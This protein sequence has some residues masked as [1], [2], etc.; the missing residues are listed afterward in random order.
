M[1][2]V[3]FSFLLSIIL[4]FA[5]GLAG[6]SPVDRSESLKLVS[7]DFELADGPSWSGWALTV[8]DPKSQI[9]K[10]FI[11]KQKKWHVVAKE[12]RFSASFFNHGKTYFAS[13]RQPCP[14]QTGY[15]QH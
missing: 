3:Q 14:C 9:A 8:P 15:R 11:L 2:P 1:K 12:K 7:D 5:G 13:A 6:N 10:R 4:C